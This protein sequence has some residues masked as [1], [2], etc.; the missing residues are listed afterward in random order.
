MSPK[1]I[2]PSRIARFYFHECERYLRYSSTPQAERAAEGIPPTPY[3]TS[4]VTHAILDGGYAWEEH[5]LTTHL[6]DRVHMAPESEPNQPVRDR[7]LTADQSR[8]LL[9]GLVPGRFVYQPTLVTPAGFYEHYGIDPAVVEV[10]ECRPDIVECYEDESRD[11]RLRI[12]DVKAS[13]GVKLSH[14]IQA[15][16]YTL[17]LDHELQDW[18]VD[19]AVSSEGGVWL[20]HAEDFTTFDVR[21]MRPP[22]ATFLRDEL[23]ALMASPADQARWHLYFR[24]EWCQYFDHC[25]KEMHATND[26]SR[27]PYLTIHG[28]RYLSE[29][30]PPVRTVTDFAALLEDP[31]RVPLLEDAASLRGRAE[32]LREQTFALQEGGTRAYGGSSLGMPKAENVRMVLTLQ[33]EP[34]SGQLYAY[35]IYAQ[36]LRDIFGENPKPVVG[37]AEQGDPGP[38]EA[39]ERSFVRELSSIMRPVHDFNQER[40]E[41]WLAQKTLQ[42]F[43]FDSYER[44]LLTGLLLRRISDPEVAEQALEL[45]FFFQQPELVQAEDHPANEVFFP[46]VVLVQVIRDLLALPLEV[47]YRFGEVVR[48]LQPKQF[49]FNYRENDF[50]AFQLSNQMRSD[51]IFGVWY[52]GRDEWLQGIKT[53][54]RVR[55]WATNSLVN[56]LREFLHDH[57]NVLFAWPPKFRLPS[58]LGFQHPL[59]SRLSFIA[60]YESVVQYLAIREARMA[61]VA[62]RLRDGTCLF[63]TH[64]GGARFELDRMHEDLDIESSGFAKWI[65]TEDTDAGARARLSYNDFANRDRVWVPKN[66]PLALAAITNVETTVERPNVAVQLHVTPS[67][68]MPPLAIGH[69]YLLDQRYT[70][71]NLQRVLDELAEL[72]REERPPFV[73]LVEN[74]HGFRRDLEEATQIV[75][76]ARSLAGKHGMTAS[77]LDAFDGIVRNNL[78]LVWGPPGTG[79]THFLALAI[80]CLA[81]AHGLIDRPFRVVLTAFTHAAIDNCLRK[82][83]Q[84]DH[85]LKVVTGGMPA[86]KLG[87]RHIPGVDVEE[88]GPKVGWTWANDH[89]V[90]VLGGTVW[91]IRKGVPSYAADLVVIDEASQVKVPES[92]I[93]IRRARAGARVLMAGDHR[94]LPPIIQAAYPE[95]AE[96]EPVLYRSIFQALADQDPDG[97]YTATLLE[98]FR[99]NHTLNRYPAQQIYVPEY[100]SVDEEIGNRTI[101]LKMTDTDDD[102]M[103]SAILDPGYPLV[104]GVLSGVRA[105]AENRVEAQLVAR[106]AVKLRELLQDADGSSYQNSLDG[107]QAFWREGLF[108][109]S[110]HHAQI[111]AI[112]RALKAMRTWLCQPFVDTVDKMQGQ[113]C[114]TVIVSY[115]VSDVEYAMGEQ[116]FIYSLNRLN[117]AITRARAKTIVFLPLPLI[118]P[119][120]A[121]YE[122][123]RISEGVAFMQGLVQFARSAGEISVHDLGD[124]ELELSRVRAMSQPT[125]P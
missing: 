112:Q 9:S 42:V 99:M 48:L 70:D 58:G 10:T 22:L 50:F 121:A 78:Q 38:V 72:D 26:V 36:G 106:V 15:T 41:D 40:T 57:G 66:S 53:E 88:V 11:L 104:V 55:L 100:D 8:E 56:G 44:E 4:P 2:S 30:D 46:V 116:E 64:R 87:E 68:A 62:E 89:P 74:P 18:A 76:V 73:E 95:P 107:D 16:M 119:P 35:G 123:D 110:P 71:F 118:E 28:K 23:E 39:L 115:G 108:M 86:A 65:L 111:H 124:A 117:V 25:R 90:C 37:V 61:P 113:E 109:V 83:A 3:D 93:A 96:G 69:Q 85:D 29:L 31:T 77:Q 43:T 91:G 75:E 13:P 98:N 19:R 51:A 63:L 52:R 102:E 5:V 67:R 103:V 120:I 45:F 34:V 84:L 97:Q 105:A 47:S 79:K 27:T 24:C 60:R 32:R 114:D 94:Q 7:V 101:R 59:L 125:R 81:Q 92:S 21:S 17:I 49:G 122:D 1:Y 6:A 20:A 33:T 54:I 14:R 82:L 80:L 12:I